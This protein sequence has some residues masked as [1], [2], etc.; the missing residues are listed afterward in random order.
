MVE[1]E[2]LCDFVSIFPVFIFKWD[3]FWLDGEDG[4]VGCSSA[5]SGRRGRWPP[6]LLVFVCLTSLRSVKSEG[7]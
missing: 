3:I 6:L 7:H 2:Y 5:H 1:A 4:G